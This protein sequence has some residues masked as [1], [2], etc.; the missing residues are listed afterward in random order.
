VRPGVRCIL[1]RRL[2]EVVSLPPSRSC[3]QVQCDNT[4]DVY[5]HFGTGYYG[6]KWACKN[7]N[8]KIVVMITDE[9]TAVGNS[10]W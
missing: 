7:K 10:K 6:A 4:R 2:A 9:C 5:D 3:F 1:N 8:K